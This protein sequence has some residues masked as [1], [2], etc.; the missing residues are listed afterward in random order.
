[1]TSNKQAAYS[2]DAT[3]FTTI[4]A[5]ARQLRAEAFA[6]Y[7]IEIRNWFSSLNFGFAARTA[8]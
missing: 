8:R 4:D 6:A 7:G 1:M 5:H 2:Y 3:D